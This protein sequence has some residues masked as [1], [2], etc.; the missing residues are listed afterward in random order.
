MNEQINEQNNEQYIEQ[1]NEQN[2]KITKAA[3]SVIEKIA[4]VMSDKKKVLRYLIV[5][6]SA[7]LLCLL[8]QLYFLTLSD[9]R[10]I[11]DMTRGLSKSWSLENGEIELQKRDA[12]HSV[13]FVGIEYDAV[14]KYRDKTFRDED[15]KTMALEYIDALEKCR[16]VAET[17]DPNKDFNGFWEEFSKPYGERLAAIYRLYKN[18][19]KLRMVGS[20]TGE[21]KDNLLAQGWI[22]NK[23]EDIEFTT[24]KSED[25]VVS[26][27]GVIKNDSGYALD[28]LNLEIALYDKEGELIETAE[29]YATDIKKGGSVKLVFYQSAETEATQFRIVSESCRVR[30]AGEPEES[31]GAETSLR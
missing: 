29:A 25:G 11:R 10:F 3:E 26:F 14:A 19:Y 31:A 24:Q 4:K 6:M 2:N 17:N 20:E 13:E 18:G 28:F 16:T 15:L 22:I 9:A 12:V 5:I 27:T 21:D 8:I 1:N 7:F 23:A 30:S